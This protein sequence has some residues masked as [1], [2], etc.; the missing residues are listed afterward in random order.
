MKINFL[1]LIFFSILKFNISPYFEEEEIQNIC[2]KCHSGFNDIYKDTTKLNKTSDNDK[3]NKYVTNLVE[4][5][6]NDSNSS[7]IIDE[8]VKPRVI[9]PNIIF[10]ILIIIIIL[11]W[12]VLIVLVCKNKKY[13][14]FKE[15]NNSEDHLK[16]HLLA[17][18]TSFIF[19][20]IIVFS[21]ISLSYIYKS[22]QYF[23]GSVCSLLRIYLDV[24]DGDQA[25]TTD[26]KGVKKLQSDLV[27]DE[28]I[29]NQLIDNIEM[30]ENIVKELNN[31][32]F[33]ERTF[34]D[35]EKNNDYYSN[36]KVT[37][38]SSISSKV[39]PKYSKK[40]QDYLNIIYI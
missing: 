15:N 2:S 28:N 16:H 17:Y 1:L 14:N 23:N 39:F 25:K 22:Q 8:Y 32:K 34:A 10:I 37:S 13:L 20:I 27:G 35:G 29:V 26:W 21:S 24:R 12:I 5:L 9:N 30:Q 4:M 18:I 11:I 6:K 33:K 38:P 36:N 31:N 7:E 40:R 3:I 19:I